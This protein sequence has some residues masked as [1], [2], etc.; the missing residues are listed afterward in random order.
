MKLP[1]VKN[2]VVSRDKIVDYLLNPAHPDGAG[3]AK[4]FVALEFR[5]EYWQS[6]ADALRLVAAKNEV[7]YWTESSHG[8]KY[9]VDGQ[10]QTPD[11]KS[12]SV[13]TVWIL[14]EGRNTPRLVT[15]YPQIKEYQN[16]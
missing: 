13:R 15:A 5:V 7:V 11:G 1:N 9:I 12:P 8:S 16:D 3:T 14:D 4:F 2:A 6:L 10:I